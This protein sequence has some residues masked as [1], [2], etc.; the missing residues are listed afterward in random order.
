MLIWLS[1]L[2]HGVR[3]KTSWLMDRQ[4][5][6]MAQTECENTF[7]VNGPH[8]N[9]MYAESSGHYRKI[10]PIGWLDVESI[11]IRY[12]QELRNKQAV[13]ISKVIFF[14]CSRL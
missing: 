8:V 1:V 10:N 3:R 2:K 4:L 14:V 9:D 13:L 6:K 12:S 5:K 7:Y 11:T